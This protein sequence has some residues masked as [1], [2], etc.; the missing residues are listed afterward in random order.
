LDNTLL[1]DHEGIVLKW[2]WDASLIEAIN[3]KTIKMGNAVLVHPSKGTRDVE[4]AMPIKI[5]Y[6]PN[7][8]PEEPTNIDLVQTS[9]P[10]V[11]KVMIDGQIYI[12]RGDKLY[13]LT[14]QEVK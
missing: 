11:Q 7:E 9:A 5:N 6:V 2:V 14:G 1:T 10:S 13:T 4:E 8:E 12:L 3:G